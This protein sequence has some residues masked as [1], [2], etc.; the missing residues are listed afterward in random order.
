MGQMTWQQAVPP[1]LGCLVAIFM[2]EAGVGT[3]DQQKQIADDAAKA[4]ADA[5]AAKVNKP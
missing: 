5:I 3:P 1:A 4:A 2:K